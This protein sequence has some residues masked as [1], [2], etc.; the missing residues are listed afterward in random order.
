MS[1]AN[2]SDWCPKCR[3]KIMD[4]SCFCDWPDNE[5]EHYDSYCGAR[6][7]DQY[8]ENRKAQEFKEKIKS[9]R[10]NRV[11]GGGRQ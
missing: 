4:N 8:E 2:D 7:L 11:K 1:I 6:L 9:I 3:V 5:Q 10:F